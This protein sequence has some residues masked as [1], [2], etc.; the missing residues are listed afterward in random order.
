MNRLVKTELLKLTTVRTFA[1]ILLAGMILTLIRFAIVVFSAGKAEASPLGTASSTRDLLLSVGSSTILLLIFGVLAVTTEIRHGTIGWTFL[2]TPIRW[3]VVIAKLAAV[4]VS[5]LSYLIVVSLIV[6]GLTIGLFMRNGLPMD[7]IGGEL[8]AAL[9]GSA[10]G[11]F[12]YAGLGVGLGAIIRHQVAA[13]MI[14]L[15][16]FIVVENLLPSFGLN[17]LYA[18]LPGGATAALARSDL[19]GL[20]PMWLGAVILAGYA[21]VAVVVGVGVLSTRDLT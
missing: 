19:P 18:W 9:G 13:L 12:L 5:S 7:V 16:W 4:A 21:V 6:L 17:R 3:R 14:P 1:G 15:G 2:A 10:L 8:L 11:T 20:L